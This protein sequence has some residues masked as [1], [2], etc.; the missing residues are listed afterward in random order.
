MIK[1]LDLQTQYTSI[2]SQIDQAVIEVLENGAFVGGKF[3]ERFQ[4]AFAKE[5]GVKYALGVANGTDAIE[6]ALRALNLPYGS[7]VILPANTFFGSLEGIVNAGLKP[8]MVD[9]KEDYC[10]DPSKISQVLTSKTSAILVVHLYGKASD[11]EEILNIAHKHSL[12]VIEDCAQSFGAEIEVFGEKKRVGSIGDV[13]CFSFYP[14]KNLGAYGDGGAVSTN[15]KEVYEKCLS[16]ANHGRGEEKYRHRYIGRNSRL[17]GIQSAILS[18]KLQYIH[19]WNSH[20]I[21]VA[22]WYEE[23]LCHCDLILPPSP[24]DRQN[25]Y[26]LYV[27][28]VAKDRDKILRGL[29]SLGIEVGI[30]YPIALPFLEACEDKIAQNNCPKAVQYAKEIL[31]LPM[32][33]HLSREEVKEV[34]EKLIS[35]LN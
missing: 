13:G 7:E 1:F 2:K 23:F 18:V 24:K 33:E 11:M 28:R 17:D 26:H 5:I 20:R 15:S 30:H 12:R 10:I 9:C 27:I 22:K 6:L 8:V 3:V 14:G 25:V 16:L 19:Q 29:Q 35:L 32:G 21:Q 4:D 31:S 34:S